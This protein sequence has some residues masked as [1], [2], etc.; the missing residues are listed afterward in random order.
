MNGNHT[1]IGKIIG[2]NSHMDYLFEVYSQ[3]E[4]DDPP[5]PTDYELGQF[6]HVRKQIQEE[7]RG[8]VGVIYDTAIVDP[9]QGRAGPSLSPPE[10]QQVFQPTYVDEKRVLAGIAL[11]GSVTIDDNDEIIETDH[12]IPRW[13]L[14]VDDVVRKLPREDFEGFHEIGDEIRVE[15]YQRLVDVADDFAGDIL[16]RILDDLA[17][18]RP[19]EADALQVIKRKVRWQTTMEDL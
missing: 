19:A 4:R 8:F 2:S 10:D 13:T 5:A 18:A 17:E 3:R 7:P 16:S 14:E 15:Y 1:E 6:V 12:S 9:D 11:L